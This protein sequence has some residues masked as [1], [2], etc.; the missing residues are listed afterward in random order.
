MEIFPTMNGGVY[1]SFVEPTKSIEVVDQLQNIGGGVVDNSKAIWGK[2]E[3]GIA[4]L[5]PHPDDS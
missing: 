1:E 4:F 3:L 2:L 5:R